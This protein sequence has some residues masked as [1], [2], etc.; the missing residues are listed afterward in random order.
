PLYRAF[1]ARK[2]LGGKHPM[3]SGIALA[4]SHAMNRLNAHFIRPLVLLVITLGLGHSASAQ[5][6]TILWTGA[7][8]NLWSIAA[9]WNPARVPLTSDY[10]EI[11]SAN[12]TNV[13]LDIAASIAG[14]R[15]GQNSGSSTQML[16]VNS[17]QALTL[18]TN[19]TV[20]PNGL[21]D[22]SNGQIGGAG[23]LSIQGLM[24]WSGGTM[25]GQILVQPTGT[26]NLTGTGNKFLF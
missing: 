24:D 16:V 15:L 9:N 8:N 5:T 21:V 13:T 25:S 12:A 6:A 14:L 10:V 3:E 19:S 7:S 1:S 11:S 17:G 26:L 4:Q 18:A 23:L 2:L 22:F 20:T